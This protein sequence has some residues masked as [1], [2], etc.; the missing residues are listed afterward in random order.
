MSSLTP[1]E[2]DRLLSGHRRQQIGVLAVG[3]PVILVVVTG[4]ALIGILT[5]STGIVVGTLLGALLVVPER[6]FFRRYG[7]SRT[8][9]RLLVQVERARRSGFSA[10]P[11]EWHLARELLRARI[12]LGA[13][14][15]SVVLVLVSA[16]YFVPR[17]GETTAEGEPLDPVFTA[18]GIVMFGAIALT[19]VSVI[20]TVMWFG[21]AART[22]QRAEDERSGVDS[23]EGRRRALADYEQS[24]PGLRAA[25]DR[26]GEAVAL[27]TIGHLHHELGDQA[28]ARIVS[29]QALAIRR[30]LGDLVGEAIT[31]YNLAMIHRAEGDLVTAVAEL[32]RVVDLDRRNKHPDLLG[33]LAKLEQVRRELTRSRTGA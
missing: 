13:A 29:E 10:R 14:V 18:S 1:E 21:A 24:L 20:L 25:G 11:V 30:D 9:G 5:A 27:T 28:Q 6:M 15:L 12:S 32:E 17:A 3:V 23:P 2:F 31:R 22:R 8:A 33:D 16:S 19:V 26:A 7:L 4:M